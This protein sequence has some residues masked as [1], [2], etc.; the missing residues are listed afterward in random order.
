MESLQG[1]VFVPL[2]AAISVIYMWV[3]SDVEDQHKFREVVKMAILVSVLVGMTVMINT[4]EGS[5]GGIFDE[6]VTGPA[7]F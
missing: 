3:V 4:A 2:A 5:P 1:F 7:E 6:F